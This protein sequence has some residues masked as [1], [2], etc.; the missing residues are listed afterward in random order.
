VDRDLP[1]VPGRALRTTPPALRDPV[2]IRAAKGLTRRSLL[3]RVA[4]TAVSV[5]G[6]TAGHWTFAKPLLAL[7]YSCDY[8][9]GS[10]SGCASYVP[11]CA[12]PTG[13][14]SYSAY[15]YCPTWETNGTPCSPPRVTAV[16]LSCEYPCHGQLTCDPC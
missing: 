5:V 16:V 12:S 2:F 1:P 7:A 6:V 8:C 9:Y 3:R 11:G 13:A 15:C 14:C 4:L 10:C